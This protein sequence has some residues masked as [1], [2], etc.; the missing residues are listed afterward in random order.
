M[1]NKYLDLNKYTIKL[2]YN[3]R[4]T[5]PLIFI[6]SL[7]IPWVIIL[8]KGEMFKLSPFVYYL[9]LVV[10]GI[11]NLNLIILNIIK[12][13]Y[14]IEHIFLTLIIPVGLCYLTYIV[15]NFVP[16]EASH[17]YRAYIVSE[18]HFITRRNADKTAR[19]M[20]PRKLLE[21]L[22]SYRKYN[23]LVD[24]I[25]EKTNY[26]D[27]V[28]VNLDGTGA[29]TYSFIPYFTPSI[30]FGIGRVLNINIML[31][32]YMARIFAFVTSIVLIF[33]A[34]K[35]LPFG[36]VLML[37]YAFNPVFIQQAASLSADNLINALSMLIIAMTL[38]KIAS[39]K[40]FTKK[41]YI[42]TLILVFMLATIK[43]VYFPISF[44]LLLLIKK[45]NKKN[46][47]KI[48]SIIAVAILTSV[49]VYLF[50]SRMYN[51][52]FSH[53]VKHQVDSSG[54]VKW[55]I[56]HPIDYAGVLGNTLVEKA[57]FY[58][59]TM[60]GRNLGPYKITV[61]EIIPI[62]F[63]GL[64]I[65]SPFLEKNKFE[66]N[67]KQRLMF[68]LVFLMIYVLVETGLYVCW[69]SVGANIIEGIS[70]RYFIPIFVLIPMLFI[71]KKN[72][73][74]Y[75]HRLLFLCLALISISY[76][77]LDKILIYFNY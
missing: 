53:M 34:I 7:I 60:F 77:S 44:L 32:Y 19:M 58:F 24:G 74:T 26:N 9:I 68:F 51:T 29:A 50:A 36:K 45:G 5:Y 65:I 2:I 13:E 10:V 28:A 62:L 1:K 20:V 42:I 41:E 30:A 33:Y 46:N 56:T 40:D 38:Y 35:L 71:R 49:A 63:Y 52:E 8:Q 15:P 54:Q 14:K 48:L 64:L 18:G 75:N 22:H 67:R 3:N 47:L 59:F 25:K 27:K 11:L 6:L 61:S 17:S 37:V 66:L 76:V 70:G 73:L 23:T 31:T 43:Y 12:R 21:S 72:E 39:K 69:T 57:D 4:L 55:I 16:D